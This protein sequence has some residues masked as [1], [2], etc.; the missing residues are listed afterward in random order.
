MR[1]PI[2]RGSKGPIGI[3]IGGDEPS[4]AIEW[5]KF[6][7]DVA[8]AIANG[9]GSY[10][11]LFDGTSNAITSL[12][13]AAS[14]VKVSDPIE[15]KTWQ[16]FCLSFAWAFDDIR[17][18]QPDPTSYNIIAV[19]ALI[20]DAK[21]II[22]ETPQI[23]SIEFLDNPAS[24]PLYI[25]VRDIF[26]SAKDGFRPGNG[27]PDDILKRRFD[28]AFN[29]AVFEI[30]SR[31]SEIF[32]PIEAALRSP[33]ASASILSFQWRSYHSGLTYE[34][35]VKPIFGQ[36]KT[37]ISLS[38]IYILLRAITLDR[39][40]PTPPQNTKER[41]RK[42]SPTQ[43]KI[44]KKWTV[45]ELDRELDEWSEYSGG[46]DWLLLI[47]GGPGSGKSTTVKSFARRIASLG[48][49][50]VLLVP[51]QYIDVTKDLPEEINNF[52]I[53]RVGSPFRQRPISRD[54]IEQGHPLILIFD[55]LDELAR[56]GEAANEVTRQFVTKLTQLVATLKGDG[57]GNVKAVVTGRMPSFQAAKSYASNSE[58]RNYE[59][60]GYTAINFL[61]H[62]MSPEEIE[63]CRRDQR[64]LWWQRYAQGTGLSGHLPKAM[65]DRALSDI[66]R[67]PLLCY[68]LALSGYAVDNWEEA[69]RNRNLIYEKLLIEVWQRGWGE[70]GRQGQSKSLGRENF[71]VLMQT[72]ALAAWRGGDTRVATEKNFVESLKIMNAEEA[73]QQFV[74][75]S[76]AD[77][78]NLAMNFYLKGNDLE[79]RGFEFTHKSF[80]DYLAARALLS[81][82]QGVVHLG[83]RRV[84]AACTE[85][86]HATAS[87]MITWEIATSLRDELRLLQQRDGY[88][89]VRSIRDYFTNLAALSMNEGLPAHAIQ[90]SSWRIREAFHNNAELAI[91]TVLNAA[92]LALGQVNAADAKFKINSNSPDGLARLIDR[93]RNRARI[94][95][96]KR[97]TN[98]DEDPISELMIN[99]SIAF[100]IKDCLAF[101]DAQEID[102]FETFLDK[103]DLSYAD[104]QR[105][106][107]SGAHLCG[108]I[109]K[110]ANFRDARFERAHLDNVDFQEAI[111]ENVYF[112]DAHIGKTRFSKAQTKKLSLSAASLVCGDA[113]VDLEAISD[114]RNM[115]RPKSAVDGG[116]DRLSIVAAIKRIVELT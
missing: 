91:W 88:D 1:K 81:I 86:M 48:H 38:Q 44:E 51:L 104:L 3:P 105:A 12:L 80:G 97:G 16:L 92:T 69:A 24:L 58:R 109:V 63:I 32:A 60:I 77:I 15:Q 33:G 103:A 111:I 52:F 31:N 64:P 7:T 36:E 70:G 6:S 90:A 26:I 107:L 65:K 10:L 83:T 2:R 112:V 110:G 39:I 68:L 43:S 93:H 19:R 100:S 106:N 57:R 4:L 54:T 18:Q 23:L 95:S 78:T 13:A 30:W 45:V 101:I 5:K 21:N 35:D 82:A 40:Q 76:G 29:R 28:T 84:D 9:L 59:V 11:G 46:E 72:F 41:S 73:W 55:G 116:K 56:P 61:P 87:G 96:I 85:W 34:F 115:R 98:S 102:L 8:S 17:E 89:A 20:A 50:R 94:T 42:G 114:I 113:E 71:N 25:A 14:A 47:G 108:A 22:S 75:D 27:E 53:N 67:E 79:R 49:T 99:E 74:S 37:K 62:D 66:T